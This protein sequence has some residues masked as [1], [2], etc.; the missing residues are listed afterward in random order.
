MAHVR[1]GRKRMIEVWESRETVIVWGGRK[2]GM[3]VKTG[4]LL[5]VPVSVFEC[6]KIDS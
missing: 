4:G 2:I 3:G 1:E 6:S 5:A